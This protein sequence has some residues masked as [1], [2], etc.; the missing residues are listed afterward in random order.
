MAVKETKMKCQEQSNAFLL[1]QQRLQLYNFSD[2][3]NTLDIGTVMKNTE[4][5]D[6]SDCSQEKL[7]CISTCGIQQKNFRSKAKYTTITYN[8]RT[9]RN[10][11]QT[12][13][14][15]NFIKLRI[16]LSSLSIEPFKV[17]CPWK[18]QDGRLY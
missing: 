9:R 8:F 16:V 10:L 15:K 11:T 4:M 17:P 14:Y 6:Y 2:M 3:E 1:I 18:E 12:K 13:S 5:C 7:F